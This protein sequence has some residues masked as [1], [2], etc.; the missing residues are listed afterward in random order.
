MLPETA[1]RLVDLNRAFYQSFAATFAETRARVQ[2]GAQRLLGRIAPENAVA[3]LGC[4]NG[5]AA[6]WLAAHNHRGAYL[7]IDLSQSLLA[8]AR[9]RTYPFAADFRCADF[10]E[11]G[12]D[13]DLSKGSFPF[14]LAFALLHHIPGEP[15]RVAFLDACR[16]MLSP[17]GVLFLS[18]WQFLRSEKLRAR[19][20]PW[21]DAGFAEGVVDPGDYLLDWRRDGKG[22][23]YVHVL[24][25]QERRTLA[26]RC[27][28][29][30][31]ENFSSDG[32]NGRLADYAVWQPASG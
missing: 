5:N 4:G 21:Q 6:R 31:V 19:I 8:I 16:R 2:P 22:L 13:T 23:R 3:D 18:H 14:V 20:V 9:E 11:E 32:E 29:C 24:D 10:L 30:E 7:G 28:F 15:G 25:P 27:G 12:W 26:Q 17:D 1:R